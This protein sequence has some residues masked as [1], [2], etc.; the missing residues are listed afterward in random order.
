MFYFGPVAAAPAPSAQTPSSGGGFGSALFMLVFFFLIFYLIII[1]PQQRQQKKHK[2]M[3]SSLKK[4]DRILNQGGIV[5]KI[6]NIK[7]E[8][9]RIRTGE[10]TE[11]DISKNSVVTILA[12]SKEEEKEE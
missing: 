2:A 7:G 10:R 6:V 3:I 1:L 4:G 12:K 9:I 5:G 8:I 11:I